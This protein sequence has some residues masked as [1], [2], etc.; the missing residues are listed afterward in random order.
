MNSVKP[1][2]VRFSGYKYKDGKPE[3]FLPGYQTAAKVRAEVVRSP[4]SAKPQTDFI[5]LDRDQKSQY[6]VSPDAQKTDAKKLEAGNAYRFQIQE[7]EGAEWKNIDP[8]YL[9][10]VQ[11]GEKGDTFNRIAKHDL[12]NPQKS[13]VMI[14]VFADS[15]LTREQISALDQQERQRLKWNPEGSK[16]NDLPEDHLPVLPMRNHFNKFN[17]ITLRPKDKQNQAV[18]P[19]DRLVAKKE[20][21]KPSEVRTHGFEDGLNQMLPELQKRGFSAV[22]FKPFMGG[23]NL[24]SH[25]YWTADPYILNDTFRNKDGFRKS[26][27][28]MLQGGMKVFA[29]GAFVN[30]GLNGVQIMSNLRNG[31]NSPYWGSWFH[32]S[33]H[34]PG[35][36]TS[37]PSVA[38]EKYEFGILP[39]KDVNGN[40]KLDVDA[41][42]VRFIN[43]PDGK[44]AYGN[45]YDKKKPTFIELYDPRL[46]QENGAPKQDPTVSQAGLKNSKRSVQKYRFPVSPEELKKKKTSDG[47]KTKY[48]DWQSFRLTVP[49]ADNSS[50]KWD[51]QIDVALMNTQS[52]EVVNYLDGAV[53]YWSRMVMNH[54]TASVA[55]RMQKARKVLDKPNAPASEKDVLDAVTFTHVGQRIAQ[56]KEQDPAL[57]NPD[58]A[59]DPD[60]ALTAEKV[61]AEIG[62]LPANDPARKDLQRLKQEMPNATD[63]ALYKEITKYESLKILPP[64]THPVDDIDGAKAKAFAKANLD[65]EKKDSGKAF[66]RTLMKDVPIN[67]VQLPILVKANLNDPRFL[68]NLKLRTGKVANFIEDR[69]LG[70][71]DVPVIG[72]PFEYMSNVFFSPRVEKALG[73]KMQQVFD[74]LDSEG[75]AATKLQYKEIQSIVADQLGEPLYISLLTGK[76]LKE[77]KQLA[78]NPDELENAIYE[79]LPLSLLNANPHEAAKSLPALF[80]KRLRDMGKVGPNNSPSLKVQVRDEIN[81]ITKDLDPGLV[82]LA[83][84]VLKER[85]FGLNWR[86]DAAKDIA[87]IDSVRNEGD[88]AK[89]LEKFKDQVNYLNKFWGDKLHQSMRD[90]FP[91]SSVIAELTDFNDLGGDQG[92]KLKKDL[93]L[94]NTFTSTPN[95]DHTYSPLLQLVHYAQRPDEFGASQQSPGEFLKGELKN[96]TQEVPLYTQRQLQ[97]L[98]GS[99]DFSTTSHALLMNPVLFNL[100]RDRNIGLV[101][102][103]NVASKELESMVCFAPEREKLAKEL[104]LSNEQLSEAMTSLRDWLK[105]S[106]GFVPDQLKKIKPEPGD[107]FDYETLKDFYDQDIKSGFE[108]AASPEKRLVFKSVTP[109]DVK[110]QFVNGLFNKQ[111]LHNKIQTGTDDIGE[112][113]GST[114]DGKVLKPF[115][116]V[117]NGNPDKQKVLDALKEQLTARMRESSE[118][119]AMRGT[120]NNAVMQAAVQNDALKDENVQNAIWGGLNTAIQKWGSHFG[121]QSLD[122]AL[123]HVF[124]EAMPEL[125]NKGVDRA[126]I[127]KI[128]VDIYNQALKPVMAKQERIFAIQNALP[129]NPSVY[130]PDLFAQGGSEYIKNIYVQNRPIVRTDRLNGKN[131][132]FNEYMNN[133]GNIFNSRAQLP[134]LN[135]G[136]VLPV[137]TEA[138]DA[139][140]ILPVVRDN[141]EQQAIVLVDMGKQKIKQLSGEARQINPLDLEAQEQYSNV[142][143]NWVTS[144]RKI[145]TPLNLGLNHLKAGDRYKDQQTGEI[146]EINKAG[147]L[148]QKTPDGDKKD[149]EIKANRILVRQD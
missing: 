96:M 40:P 144:G 42:A 75:D 118:A 9:E 135:D 54:Y 146:F 25:R 58:L 11:V 80:R 142:N 112:A 41:F 17:E 85:E 141:G 4:E 22:V 149:F 21:Y 57:K 43:D 3:L 148:V 38:Q 63:S 117:V 19:Q 101:E 121:Y 128:R 8:D 140:G 67:T 10:T 126:Q 5:E 20:G 105:E 33:D 28:M 83:S 111:I 143:G 72:K 93:F 16:E 109:Q 12:D 132:E 30:Q 100:D 133:V 14:D 139:N 52:E 66:A 116:D 87:D 131:P 15:V 45:P 78:Q 123:N 102:Y 32:F 62:K 115:A 88:P 124:E 147:E 122:V 51:G 106:R 53:N 108:K 79:S 136:I 35:S 110:D 73:R 70:L 89:R 86:I 31:T 104:G 13:S 91:K 49:G 127:E 71:I 77:A 119:K 61:F 29:D 107:N 7:S 60:L 23:D 18:T 95:M 50:K 44:D 137:E 2:T 138:A 76:S 103:F 64:Q 39:T 90:I 65:F 129:G 81:R 48:L 37:Y 68:Q 6:W 74:E 26:L 56:F 134:V 94:N 1:P 113:I 59:K 145:Q 92:Q 47:G 82:S 69:L 120:I 125:V 130:L 98:T 84:G 97:N 27:D 114:D 55:E 24:S 99:H 46:E 34:K 36:K